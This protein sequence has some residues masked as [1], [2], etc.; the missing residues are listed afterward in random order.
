MDVSKAEILAAAESYHA[1]WNEAGFDLPCAEDAQIWL[2]QPQS[3]ATDFDA[4]VRSLEEGA[5]SK[6]ERPAVDSPSPSQTSALDNLPPLPTT[7]SAIGEFYACLSQKTNRLCV[8]PMGDALAPLCIITDMPTQAD[9]KAGRLFS[10]EDGVLLDN[11]L[12]AIGLTRADVCIIAAVPFFTATN[13]DGQFGDYLSCLLRRQIS[14]LTARHVLN[15]GD[16]GSQW[17]LG[18]NAAKARGRLHDVN[19]DSGHISL[20]TS[21]HPIGLL[22]RPQFKRMAWQD[23]QLVAKALATQ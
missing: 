20:S 11:M 2:R 6:P 12:K 22:K 1:W 21:F 23:L 15:F 18:E 17:L 7:F 14:L 4:Y 10:G 5:S 9:V 16:S 3:D 13:G 19:H 8:A